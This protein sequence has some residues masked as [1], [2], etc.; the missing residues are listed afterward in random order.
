[1]Q[2]SILKK[3]MEDVNLINR[4]VK[5]EEISYLHC[6]LWGLYEESKTKKILSVEELKRLREMIDDIISEESIYAS[7]NIIKFVYDNFEA[8]K[9]N[10]FANDVVD[11]MV[12]QE[13]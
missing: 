12:A 6:T 9:N 10:K 8:L 13:K 11:F 4:Y 3:I 1:M 5:E 2:K 7:I